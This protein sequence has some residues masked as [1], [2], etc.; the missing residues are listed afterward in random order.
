MSHIRYTCGNCNGPKLSGQEYQPYCDDCLRAI[1][2][3]R[4]EADEKNLGKSLWD[5]MKEQA[6]EARRSPLGMAAKGR[7]DAGFSRI[8]TTDLERRVPRPF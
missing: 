6:L 8:D 2:A 4:K 3:A 1:E 5:H 7:P